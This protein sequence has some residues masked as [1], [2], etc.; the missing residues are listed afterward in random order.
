MTAVATAAPLVLVVE[1]EPPMRRFLHSCL[2]GAGYRTSEAESG[3]QA[4]AS[5]IDRPPDVVLLDLGL[6]D[7]DGQDVL[8]RLREW[9][10]A[11][12]IILSVRN[13]D[14]QKITALNRGADDFM[15]KP[16]ST[17]ELLARIRVALRHVSQ[18]QGGVESPVFEVGEL[19]VDLATRR[20][21]VRGQEVHL[22]RLEYKLITLLVQHAGKVVTYPQ[23][24]TEV[25]GPQQANNT[26]H[27]RVFMA[28]LR[29]KLELD[30][31]QPQYLLTEQGVGYRL[32]SE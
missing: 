11:P 17:G 10:A 24:L 18:R 29:R 22:T 12:I 30:P 8:A 27:L 23:I 4:I 19:K 31:A 6:P 3:E 14:S 13:Q 2:S 1:D 28:G 5:A 25:W 32:A 15:T 26:Q 7:M 16:F 20:I 9:L 21:L